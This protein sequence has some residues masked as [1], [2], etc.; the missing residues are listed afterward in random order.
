M[1]L[2]KK[3]VTSVTPS[4]IKNQNLSGELL[5]LS[6]YWKGEES[7][8]W[9]Q[10]RLP[11]AAV[12]TATVTDTFAQK[13]DIKA[14]T[15]TAFFFKPLF[16]WTTHCKVPP[17]SRVGLF[18]SVNPFWECSYKHTERCLL[19]DPKSQQIKSQDQPSQTPFLPVSLC[20]LK[21]K[22]SLADNTI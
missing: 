8:I 5:V 2:Y 21:G 9:C 13:E 18:H 15:H 6:L 14:A 10:W 11:A 22:V 12:W 4:G 3:P 1:D 7:G 20:T 16:I 19:S 17:T